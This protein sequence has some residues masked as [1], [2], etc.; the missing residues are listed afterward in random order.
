VERV[1]EDA[2]HRV[3][4]AAGGEKRVERRQLVGIDLH[5]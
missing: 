4:G 1:H 2:A 5:F 3:H